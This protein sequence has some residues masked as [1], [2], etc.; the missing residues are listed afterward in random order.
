MRE[1]RINVHNHQRVQVTS[2][3][4]HH[5]QQNE[6]RIEDRDHDGLANYQLQHLMYNLL[7]THCDHFLFQQIDDAEVQNQMLWKANHNEAPDEVYIHELI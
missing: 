4:G 2:T 6:S 7:H 5:I 1:T 3:Q